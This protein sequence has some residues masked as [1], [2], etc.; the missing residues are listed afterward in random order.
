MIDYILVTGSTG[1]LG[2]HI[3]HTLSKKYKN[4]II[5]IRS[6]SDIS[7]IKNIKELLFGI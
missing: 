2:I 1:F 7:K 5:L 3:V 4:I 6:T